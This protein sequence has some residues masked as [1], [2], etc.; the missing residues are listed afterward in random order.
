MQKKGKTRWHTKVNVEIHRQVFK[1]HLLS[2]G[3][4]IVTPKRLI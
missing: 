4:A 1:L 2:L 3:S